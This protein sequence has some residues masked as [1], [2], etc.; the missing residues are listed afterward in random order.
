MNIDEARLRAGFFVGECL[1]LFGIS[2]RTWY[3]WCQH[4]APAWAFM[5]LRLRA[6]N[7]DQLGWKHWQIRNG[8]LYFDGF[9]SHGYNWEPGELLAYHWTRHNTRE[10]DLGALPQTPSVARK[11]GMRGEPLPRTPARGL[12]E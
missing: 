12:I 9:K 3:R 1:E 6:G 10:V 8:I 11:A 7:L 4:G 2:L 5:L